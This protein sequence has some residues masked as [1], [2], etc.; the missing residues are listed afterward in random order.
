MT[1]TRGVVAPMPLLTSAVLV[2]PISRRTTSQWNLWKKSSALPT[3][4]PSL[5]PIGAATRHRPSPTR[6]LTACDVVR[7]HVLTVKYQI[8]ASFSSAP[9]FQLR[10]SP[11]TAARWMSRAKSHAPNAER[12]KPSNP[13]TP[14]PT[15][16]GRQRSLSCAMHVARR[17]SRAECRAPDGRCHTSNVVHS[18]C[19]APEAARQKPVQATLRKPHAGS[20]APKA[21]HRRTL[22][23]TYLLC[24]SHS[25]SQ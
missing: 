6:A 15:Q 12:R 25:L 9:A 7:T 8:A 3:S 10:P 5:R 22:S 23:F 13:R 20:G 16:T 21:A 24:L 11:A 2:V 18:L 19:R 14:A 17:K 1:T 4:S